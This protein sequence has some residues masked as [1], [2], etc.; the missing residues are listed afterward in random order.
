MPPDASFDS[1][2]FTDRFFAVVK[3]L[4]EFDKAEVRGKISSLIL[5]TQRDI[6]FTGNYYRCVANIETLLSL[7]K[8]SDFQ[9]IA[10][11]ARALFEFAVDIE[12][13]NI[14]PDSVTKMV[15]FT[16]VE[17][18]RSA[19]RIVAFKEKNPSAQVAEQI[20]KEYIAVNGDRID[21]ERAD[22]WP[23]VKNTDLRHWA[24]LSLPQRVELLKGPLEELHAVNYPQLSLYVHSGMTGIVNLKAETFKTLAGVAFTVVLQSYMV[25]LAAIIQEFKL[26]SAD[27]KIKEKMTLAK[28]LPFTDSPA[29]QAAL[30]QAL[31]R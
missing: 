9:A 1:G 2:E 18:I 27:E 13:I 12:L 6:C 15:T 26:S 29:E 11:L 19:R 24:H 31:L 5:P 22:C 4:N 21:A 7:K 10:M 23:G 17:K 28:M 8:V 25:L 3:S 14:V 20:Y 30:T 16:D